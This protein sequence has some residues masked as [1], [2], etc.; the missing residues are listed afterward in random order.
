MILVEDVDSPEFLAEL[1]RRIFPG[2][3]EPKRKDCRP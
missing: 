2:L 3:P 1:L